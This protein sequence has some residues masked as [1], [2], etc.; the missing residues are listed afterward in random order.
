[1]TLRA[2]RFREES[3]AFRIAQCLN[4]IDARLYAINDTL[5]LIGGYMEEYAECIG[6][7]IN[8]R[9]K[10]IRVIDLDR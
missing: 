4:E 7:G 1:M 3:D 2:K 5:E 9:D 6:T 8:S 10:F